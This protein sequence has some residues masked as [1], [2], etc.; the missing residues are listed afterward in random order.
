LFSF[1]LSLPPRIPFLKLAARVQ[2]CSPK[3]DISAADNKQKRS[4]A[5]AIL[6]KKTINSEDT[7][8]HAEVTRHPTHAK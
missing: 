6:K 3:S 8:R 4:Q 5:T 7:D 1:F 2:A